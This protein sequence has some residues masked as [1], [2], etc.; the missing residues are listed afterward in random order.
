MR[1]IGLFCRL[2]ALLMLIYIGGLK[3]VQTRSEPEL[4][5]LVFEDYSTTYQN[6]LYLND[7]KNTSRLI[8]TP[9]SREIIEAANAQRGDIVVSE[10]FSS[11]FMNSTFYQINVF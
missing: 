9:T 2:F 5:W 11:S 3:F 8:H 6:K 4:F 1:L 10:F 7:G